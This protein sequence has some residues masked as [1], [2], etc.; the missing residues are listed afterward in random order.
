MDELANC[1]NLQNLCELKIVREK[2][3]DTCGG[4]S[5]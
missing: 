3:K 2:C 4:C 1:K 5:E